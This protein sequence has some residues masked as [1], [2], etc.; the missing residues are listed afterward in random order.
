[1]ADAANEPA[2]D[3]IA[4]LVPATL[5]A[6]Y[7]LEFAGRHLSPAHPAAADRGRRRPRRRSR[8]RAAASRALDWP[9]R[10][11]PARDCLERA[12]S[13][14]RGPRRPAVA[15]R[16]AAADRRGLPG[17]A[18]L[19]PRL[20]KRSIR[21]RR[22]CSRSASS[23][24][25]PRRAT[26]R[27]CID[28][29]A[30]LDPSRDDVGVMHVGGPAGTR[31]AFSLY[32]PEYL[33]RR[34]PLPL[35]VAMHGG[36]GNG[37]AFLWSWLREAR[38]RGL[39]VLAPTASGSTWSLMEPDVDGAEHRPHGRGGRGPMERR[40]DA[41]AADRH[42]RRRHLHLCARAWRGNCRF[43]HLAPI[44]AAFHPDDD[45]LRRRRPRARPADPYRAWRAGLDV[46]AR[47]GAQR[48]AHAGSR[49]APRSSIARSPISRTPIRA[50]RMP[51]SSTGSWASKVGGPQV[52]RALAPP[53]VH[54]GGS[55]VNPLAVQVEGIQQA[56]FID[57][58][59]GLDL[60]QRIFIDEE[61]RFHCA[62]VPPETHG[63]QGGIVVAAFVGELDGH[64]I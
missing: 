48:R 64:V 28:R 21:W 50:T 25:N 49:P 59:S 5:R 30:A 1:M 22:I 38:T 14:G 2:I 37:G 52:V 18:H 9:E 8:R 27:R 3:A 23:S 42:E 47:D 32:V 57:A 61:R 31:G 13:G 58:R 41:P 15:P 56:R 26:T 7:A 40:S 63:M 20:P 16:G 36:S 19:R 51:R 10:L 35:V 44:A 45:D 24:S 53:V 54:L 43:T 33:R 39:I 11:A 60:L 62:V 46:P 34:A 29:L 12:A 6:L 55:R 17:A 4:Q